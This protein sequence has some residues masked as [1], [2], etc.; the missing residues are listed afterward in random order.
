MMRAHISV[1]EEMPF[2]ETFLDKNKAVVN[3]NAFE[4]WLSDFRRTSKIESLSICDNSEKEWKALAEEVGCAW[5]G[6]NSAVEVL[7]EMRR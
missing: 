1:I 6:N 7:S 5:K 2:F 3:I 4:K